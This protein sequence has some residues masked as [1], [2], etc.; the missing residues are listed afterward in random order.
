M[1]QLL[2]ENSPARLLFGKVAHEGW[3]VSLIGWGIGS[4]MV[5]LAWAFVYRFASGAFQLQDVAALAPI[6]GLLMQYVQLRGAGSAGQQA[7]G[8][9]INPHGGP[10]AP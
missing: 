4:A 7:L 9:F 3:R 1:N 6:A 10:A 2:A 5:A 8:D